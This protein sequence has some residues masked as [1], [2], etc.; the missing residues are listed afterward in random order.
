MKVSRSL[1]V[2]GVAV[3]ERVDSCSRPARRGRRDR[4]ASE[5]GSL[6]NHSD[7][8]PRERGVHAALPSAPSRC[9]EMRDEPVT[10]ACPAVTRGASTSVG[11]PGAGA[12]VSLGPVPW[13]LLCP[14]RRVGGVSRAAS[15]GAEAIET[16]NGVV[17]A[18][19]VTAAPLPPP[20]PFPLSVWPTE[21]LLRLSHRDEAPRRGSAAPGGGVHTP[22]LL[23][24]G[25]REGTACPA[26][27]LLPWT[28]E[29]TFRVSGRG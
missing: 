9:A 4:C 20:A 7:P 12:C 27:Q 6:R 29:T 8:H 11:S 22:S 24:A 15:Q 17:K 28:L 21:R 26:R 14:R 19:P 10:G 16:E 18:R 5:A 2:R 13:R 25:V 3:R 1:P 23:T